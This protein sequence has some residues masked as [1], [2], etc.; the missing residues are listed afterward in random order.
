V[1]R[2]ICLI[3]VAAAI[4]ACGGSPAADPSPAAGPVDGARNDSFALEIR[5]P[6][7]RYAS[8]E[9][10]AIDTTIAYLGP[11]DRIVASSEYSTLV[12]FGLEQIDGPLDM[13][14]GGSDLMCR[15]LALTARQPLAVGFAKSGA[16]SQNDPT[17]AFWDAYFADRLLHLPAGTWRVT[18]SLRAWTTPDCSGRLESLDTG[19]TFVVE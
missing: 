13:L 1:I 17:A 2:A 18:A 8:A 9:A 4:A 6:R 16:Y 19:V 7:D 10:I 3:V 12:T 11:R 15:T 14:D 5:T